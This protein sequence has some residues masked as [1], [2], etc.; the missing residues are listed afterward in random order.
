VPVVMMN[1]IG[2]RLTTAVGI[3]VAE[4]EVNVTI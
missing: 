3:D 2:I 4:V 1:A